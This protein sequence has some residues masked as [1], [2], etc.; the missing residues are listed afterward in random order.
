[1][2]FL[3][4]LRGEGADPY[5]FKGSQPVDAGGFA[6]HPRGNYRFNGYSLV[7]LLVLLMWML[8]QHCRC[9]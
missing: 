5:V 9:N 4:V 7:L 6:V 2:I 3:F 1:M 8:L